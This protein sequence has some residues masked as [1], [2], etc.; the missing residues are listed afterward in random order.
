MSGPYAPAQVPALNDPVSYLKLPQHFEQIF[1]V[2]LIGNVVNIDEGELA[3]FIDN[4]ESS[5]LM[6]SLAR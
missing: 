4:E 2:R 5:S 1:I 6:P 3:F